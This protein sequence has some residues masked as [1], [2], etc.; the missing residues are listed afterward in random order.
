MPLSLRVPLRP[1]LLC[2]WC[3]RACSPASQGHNDRRRKAEVARA[4]KRARRTRG[5][6]K[7]AGAGTKGGSGETKGEPEEEGESASLL[8]GIEHAYVLKRPLV[9]V[10]V[11]LF[12]ILVV[13]LQIA[14]PQKKG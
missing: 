6:T 8:C 12:W 11:L 2:P 9:G 4:P 14:H 7:A 1:A 3:A 10:W 5:G 13:G